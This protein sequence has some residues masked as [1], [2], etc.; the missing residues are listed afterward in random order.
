LYYGAAGEEEQPVFIKAEGFDSRLPYIPHILLELLNLLAPFY[1]RNGGRA[2]T[3]IH[4]IHTGTQ[5]GRHQREGLALNNTILG[6]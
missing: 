4:S 2:H 3:S 1:L 6:S 5:A